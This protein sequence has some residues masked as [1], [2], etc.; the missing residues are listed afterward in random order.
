MPQAKPELSDWITKEQAAELLG[1]KERQVQKR[2][3]QGYI[4]KRYL[5]RLPNERQARV[6]YARRDV[7]ALA[8]GTPNHCQ[9]LPAATSGNGPAGPQQL[10]EASP[11]P[12]PD[13]ALQAAF[14][15]Y[16]AAGMPPLTAEGAFAFPR[17][18]EAELASVNSQVEAWN[19]MATYLTKLSNALAPPQRKAFLTFEEAI[20]YSGLPAAEIDRLLREGLIY[21][22][23]RGPKTW[24]IQRASL[25]AYGQAS[26]Q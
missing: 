15:Q 12:K 22:F 3:E 23:G 16:V 7:D 20:A 2:A 17:L 9:E 8:A 14:A 1:L 6:M 4:E 21:S 24:R 26:H 5:P 13:A 11:A 10:G 18:P 19:A 25:D